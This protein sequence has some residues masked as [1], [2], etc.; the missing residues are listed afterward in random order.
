VALPDRRLPPKSTWVKA[1]RMHPLI[2]RHTKRSK[3]LYSSRGAGER[4]FGRL[5]H[6]WA[7]LPL[8]VRVS[9]AFAFTPT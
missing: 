7:M 3:A 1:D 8:R 9:S 4:E 6:E 2:P 5:K